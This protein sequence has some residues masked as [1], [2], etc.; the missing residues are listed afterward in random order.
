MNEPYRLGEQSIIAYLQRLANGVST[1]EFDVAALPTEL[2]AIGEQLQK[3]FAILQQERELLER[4][5][6]IDS[7]TNLGNRG[8]LDCHIDQLW[9]KGVP[10]TCAYI[11]IDHL[12]HCNDTFG[13]AEGNR[14]ILS[15]CR[16]LTETME[17]NDLLFRIGGDEFVLI[18]PRQTNPNSSSA[19]SGR[20]P[21]LSRQYRAAKRP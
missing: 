14:Y 19:W 21:T 13:H 15:I 5:A 3:T 9:R 6:Y 11:D 4:G 1:A 17:P 16:A 8:G 20:A 7:L 2:C 10:F 18:S 12:K